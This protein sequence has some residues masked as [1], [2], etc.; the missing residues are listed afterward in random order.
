MTKVAL[1][2]AAAA[3]CVAACR[4]AQHYSPALFAPPAGHF[5]Y[6]GGDER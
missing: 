6:D 3:L 4:L 1:A 2:A 5:S